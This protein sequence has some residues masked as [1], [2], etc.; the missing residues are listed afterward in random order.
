[1]TFPN[2]SVIAA[3]GW[4]KQNIYLSIYHLTYAKLL[5]IVMHE[6]MKLGDN[7]PEEWEAVTCKHKISDKMLANSS[8]Y[9]TALQ[10]INNLETKRSYK[11]RVNL[12]ILKFSKKFIERFKK[13]SLIC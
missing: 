6:N 8:L 3:S 7:T 5:A 4:N 10:Y 1:M 9:F 13:Y 12:K 2:N 11:R